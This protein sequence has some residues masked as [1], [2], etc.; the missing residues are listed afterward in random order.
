MVVFQVPPAR[1]YAGDDG[2]TDRAFNQLNRS[3][4]PP[5]ARRGDLGFAPPPARA[6][7]EHIEMPA[8][9]LARG[10]ERRH[11]LARVG[12]LG[13]LLVLGQLGGLALGQL[14]AGFVVGQAGYRYVLGVA[15]VAGQRPRPLGRFAHLRPPARRAMPN[16]HAPSAISAAAPS[17]PAPVCCKTGW[18]VSTCAGPGAQFGKHGVYPEG[19][20]FGKHDARMSQTWWMI[21]RTAPLSSA[22]FTL[23]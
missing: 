19:W 11:S 13:G 4:A 15:A 21:M 8:Y 1:L 12:H 3:D 22:G 5:P 6:L 10:V 2:K 18:L 17:A 14:A 7:F 20:Q 9:L 16:S 23:S